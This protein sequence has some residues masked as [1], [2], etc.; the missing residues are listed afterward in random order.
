[1][2]N[3]DIFTLEESETP[4]YWGV[5]LPILLCGALFAHFFLTWRSRWQESSHPRGETAALFPA[6]P[7]G[8][9]A[10]PPVAALS[11]VTPAPTI[12]PT[13]PP[14]PAATSLPGSQRVSPMDGLV[15]VYIPAGDFQMGRSAGDDQFEDDQ[16]QHTVWLDA[17]WIGLTPVTNAA[18]ALCE[19]EG[20]CELP[21]SPETNPHYYDPAYT[22]HPVV[23]VTW[24]AAQD[25]CRWAG[26]RL[27]TE[28]EWERTAGADGWREYPWGD[29]DPAENLANLGGLHD[30]T[31]P[32]GSFPAGASPFGVLDMGGN[33]REWVADWY[34]PNYYQV[35][36]AANPQGPDSGTMRA[37]RG[38]SWND[39]W[40]YAKLTR[41]YAHDPGSPG[42]NRGFRCV[43]DE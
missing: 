35:S 39:P 30:E 16:P 31:T 41:R 14:Q 2:E 32:V 28:A 42:A 26:G 29:P 27:P 5:V 9:T 43:F 36:A 17:F 10:S 18:Y 38:A 37:L 13:I 8:T 1:M 33:V 3:A 22:S 19:A 15:Q 23:Y 34:D 12:A 6:A 21:C 40:Y 20:I 4:S 11:L 25:Y 7:A 24:Q